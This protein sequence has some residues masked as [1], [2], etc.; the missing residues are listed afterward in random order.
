MDN[1]TALPEVH[2]SQRQLSASGPLRVKLLD[3][4]T[5]A[6]DD[7]NALWRKISTQDYAFDDNTRDDPRSF[8]L[9]L[10]SPASYHFLVDESA[11]VVV[12]NVW[13]DSDCQIHFVLWDRNFSFHNVVEAGRQILEWAFKEQGV[14][15]VSAY[16]PKFNA[17]AT[18]FASTMGFKY[19]GTLRKSL[20]F[21]GDFC[22][23]DIYG[24]LEK[25]FE[26]RFQQ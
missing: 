24:I 10:V 26:R 3:P 1:I 9:N 2:G 12:R 6:G 15:R 23:V 18:R 16:I 7:M 8:V 11:Y 4:K 5:M 19:E 21:H 25:E 20:K 14:N 22:D 17:L 13:K